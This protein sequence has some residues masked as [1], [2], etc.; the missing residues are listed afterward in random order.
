MRKRSHLQRAAVMITASL[1]L[2]MVF[3]SISARSASAA[4][5]E[6]HRPGVSCSGNGCNNQDP[7]GT[8]CAQG[9]YKRV[10]SVSDLWVRVELEYSY[11]CGT[12]WTQVYRLDGHAGYASGCVSRKSGQDGGAL[13]YCYASS[14]YSWIN[15]NQVWAP[16]NVAQACGNGGHAFGVC[17]N[18]Y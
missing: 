7:Y 17:T 6:F 5:G 12:N 2:A 10:A 11:A 3:F 1:V 13:S 16:H 8:G 4:S 15:T 9:G 14:R 18:W